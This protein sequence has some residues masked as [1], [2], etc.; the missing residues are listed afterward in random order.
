MTIF[1]ALEKVDRHLG[2]LEFRAS[3]APPVVAGA[4]CSC[5]RRMEV[6]DGR[7]TLTDDELAAAADVAPADVVAR[8]VA[9]VN[10]CRDLEV[11]A[12]LAEFDDA[13]W[14]CGSGDLS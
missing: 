1:D 10:A 8:I 14:C 5:G 11:S 6:R 3:F 9:T 13:H 12:A 2:E 4:H 7:I